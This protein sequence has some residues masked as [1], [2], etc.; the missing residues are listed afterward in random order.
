MEKRPQGIEKQAQHFRRSARLQ[1]LRQTNEA[2]HYLPFQPSS[3]KGTLAIAVA[4]F[5]LKLMS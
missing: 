3:P 5:I 4:N 1:D 2:K